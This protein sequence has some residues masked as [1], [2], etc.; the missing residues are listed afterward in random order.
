MPNIHDHYSKMVEKW[1]ILRGRDRLRERMVY[2]G[3][4]M[5]PKN[6]TEEEKE[7]ECN[8][9]SEWTEKQSIHKNLQ[10]QSSNTKKYLN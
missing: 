6:A 7:R 1:N 8:W 4:T 10:G 5:R 3:H 2:S 9:K